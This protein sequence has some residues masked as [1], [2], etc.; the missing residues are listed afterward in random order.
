MLDQRM[1]VSNAIAQEFRNAAIELKTKPLENA[2]VLIEIDGRIKDLVKNGFPE[3]RDAVFLQFFYAHLRNHLWMHIAAEV[4]TRISDESTEAIINKIR[5]GLENLAECIE[6][7]DK[8]K[9]YDALAQLVYDYHIELTKV[10]LVDF[11]NEKE[12]V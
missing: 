5:I 2:H 4:S 9:L 7:D 11:R 12:A 1:A 3:N 8:S 6:N 10:K